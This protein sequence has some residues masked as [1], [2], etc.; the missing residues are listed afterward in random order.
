MQ[1]SLGADE[2]SAHKPWSTNPARVHVGEIKPP[3]SAS[4]CWVT[5]GLQSVTLG[6]NNTEVFQIATVTFYW[7]PRKHGLKPTLYTDKSMWPCHLSISSLL[8]TGLL[9]GHRPIPEAPLDHWQAWRKVTNSS[10]K[11][12]ICVHAEKKKGGRLHMIYYVISLDWASVETNLVKQFKLFC[13]YRQLN[14]SKII[15]DW[16]MFLHWIH[17][18]IILV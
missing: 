8:H 6:M 10:R 13:N 11:N 18:H 9:R 2:Q 7:S 3:R 14:W 17:L 5:S 12:D 15:K 1:A 4:E 16:N